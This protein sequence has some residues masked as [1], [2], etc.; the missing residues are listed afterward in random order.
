MALFRDKLVVPSAV[1][2]LVAVALLDYRFQDVTL[3]PLVAI[4][5][6]VIA[7]FGG[8]W[9]ALSL[10]VMTA[11]VFGYID[12]VPPARIDGAS[13]PINAAVMAAGFCATV[14]SAALLQ[15]ETR[16]LA[17][18]RGALG[19]ARQTASKA[20]ILARTDRLTELLNRRGFDEEI[21]RLRLESDGLAGVQAVFF[22]DLDGLK[23]IN[24]AHGHSVGDLALQT[25][26]RR[27][28]ASVRGED[29]VARIGGDEFAVV[30]HAATPGEINAKRI[31]HEI[32]SVCAEPMAFGGRSIG[33]SA[34]IG[35]ARAP[36]DGT[37][38]SELLQ[39]ADQRMYESKVAA[40][41]ERLT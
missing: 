2:F 34:S 39:M 12:Y 21:E 41:A 11:V 5:L 29:I 9:W 33:L 37:E 24:D 31:A 16:R 35:M 25:V 23:E 17:Y 18:L 7:Y 20:L 40:R 8:L 6:L 27:V 30:C 28:A 15:R 14:I 26:A 36:Q 32:R 13:F 4:P 38:I 1:T 3:A 22:I 19:S 10:A